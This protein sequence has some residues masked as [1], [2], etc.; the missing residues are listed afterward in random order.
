MILA[1]S[2][3]VR[4]VAMMVYSSLVAQKNVAI[5]TPTTITAAVEMP[6]R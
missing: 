6:N 4:S 2:V 1:A 3:G 5:T